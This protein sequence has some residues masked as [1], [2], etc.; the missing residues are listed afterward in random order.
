M[1]SWIGPLLGLIPQALST[2]QGITS[3]IANERLALI[4]AKTDQERQASQERIGSLEVRRDVLI[5]ESKGSNWN[6]YFRSFIALSPSLLLAKL[7]FWDKTV[8]PFRGC[9]EKVNLEEMP[10]CASHNT[11]KL[12]PNIWWVI[13]IVLCFY[14]VST[15]KKT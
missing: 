3:A 12:D 10:W 7:F 8:G 4:S 2:V 11:D 6:L 13:G 14:F 5:A 15:M 1:L 9:V